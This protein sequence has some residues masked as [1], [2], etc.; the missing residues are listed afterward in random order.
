MNEDIIRAV[1][2]ADA[3]EGLKVF[4]VGLVIAAAVWGL[5]RLLL[6][7]RRRGES[8]RRVLGRLAFWTVVVAAFLVA[9]TVI[10]PSINPVDVLGGLGVVSIA[11]GIAFQTVLG[12]MFAGIVILSRDQFRVGDQVKVEDNAGQIVG[13]YLSSTAIRTFDGQLVIV[14]NT[15]MHSSQIVVQTGFERTRA[16]V[17]VELRG[18]ADL[19][20]ARTAAESAMRGLDLVLNDPQPRALFTEV[21]VESVMMELIFWSGS[22]R[23]E[24]REATDAVITAVL[25]AFREGSVPLA[26]GPAFPGP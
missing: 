15:T 11:A 9:L 20:H 25:A 1:T 7:A 17:P 18:D 4:G 21:G 16:T 14:P 5:V 19:E 24:A 12:N 10:F 22:T 8:S 13:I 6:T 2:W 23:L 3:L 26:E